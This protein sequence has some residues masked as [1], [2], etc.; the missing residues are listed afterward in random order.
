MAM[1]KINYCLCHE[2]TVL[3]TLSTRVSHMQL[4]EM[5]QTLMSLSKPN[6]MDLK[7][8]K[9]MSCLSNEQTMLEYVSDVLSLMQRSVV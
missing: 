1:N 4:H 8:T 2:T 9:L 3:S 5:Y 7:L 6:P